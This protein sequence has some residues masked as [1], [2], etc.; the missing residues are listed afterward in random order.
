MHIFEKLMRKP[1][2]WVELETVYTLERMDAIC[3]R[4]TEEQIPH[5]VRAALLPTGISSVFPA[6]TQSLWYLSV[7][8][9][10]ASRAQRCIRAVEKGV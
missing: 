4:L 7:P 6:C 10:D 9:E 1:A 3:L 8:E 5:R 2:R